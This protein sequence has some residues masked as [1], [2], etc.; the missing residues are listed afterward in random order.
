MTIHR[1]DSACRTVTLASD[2]LSD[3]LREA[4]RLCDEDPATRN[5]W[6]I[7]AKWDNEECGYVLLIVANGASRAADRARA[8]FDAE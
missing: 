7:S 4:G 5:V 3:L 6:E 2:S 1:H 8:E